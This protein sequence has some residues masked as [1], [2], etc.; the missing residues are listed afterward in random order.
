M[1]INTCGNLLISNQSVK[2]CGETAKQRW[3][4]GCLDSFRV[5]SSRELLS[6]DE[7][8]SSADDSDFEEMGKNIE[9]LLSNKKSSLQ[10]GP[11]C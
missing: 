11:D 10:V 1:V 4:I 3:L 2:T 8:S 9:N 6:T 5:L 7:D